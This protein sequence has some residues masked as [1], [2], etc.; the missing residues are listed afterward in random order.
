MILHEFPSLILAP[1]LNFYPEA[2]KGYLINLISIRILLVVYGS[3]FL[4][5]L[6]GQYYRENVNFANFYPDM[7]T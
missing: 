7:S 6:S 2:A 4:K 3:G 1:A 5:N